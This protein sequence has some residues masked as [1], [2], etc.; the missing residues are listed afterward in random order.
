MF[1]A[2]VPAVRQPAGAMQGR[3][4]VVVAAVVMVIAGIV[5]AKPA[6]EDKKNRVYQVRANLNLWQGRVPA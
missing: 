6:D 5:T 2:Q 4:V 3:E 1:H